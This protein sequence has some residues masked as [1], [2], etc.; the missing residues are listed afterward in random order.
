[1]EKAEILWALKQVYSGLSDNSCKDVVSL[2]QSVF[3]ESQ[4]AQKIRLEPNKLKYMVNHG[5]APYVKDILRDDV[6]KSDR[7]VVSF[8]ESMNDITQTS[9]M[10]ICL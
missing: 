8:N 1:M 4:I 7:Y 10:D 6:R 3:L 9:E 2:F 5:I